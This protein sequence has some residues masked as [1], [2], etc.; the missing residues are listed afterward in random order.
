MKDSFGIYGTL[1]Y[2]LYD[3]KGNIKDEGTIRNQIQDDLREAIVDAL[4]TGS[5]TAVTAM[6]IGTGNSQASSD[7]VLSSKSS[8]ED[9]TPS[10]P[11]ADQFKAEASFTNVTATI[12][13]AGL[14]PTSACDANMYTY[15]DGLNVVM[16]SSD[17]LALDWTIDVDYST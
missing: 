16:T 10:Q 1:H 9:I 6:A 11:S 7:T 2:T 12:T 8:D 15:N 13:E 14:F 4:E 17:T 3:N 5:M